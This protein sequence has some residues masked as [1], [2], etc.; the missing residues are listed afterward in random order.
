MA[1]GIFDDLNPETRRRWAYPDT[2][3]WDP[4]RNTAEFLAAM[5]EWRARY[6]AILRVSDVRAIL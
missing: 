5:A 3:V 6:S 2:G 1:Q 4:G